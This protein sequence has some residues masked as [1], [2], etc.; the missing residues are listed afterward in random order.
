[1]VIVSKVNELFQTSGTYINLELKFKLR[2]GT[3]RLDYQENLLV[4][5]HRRQVRTSEEMDTE[6]HN[7]FEQTV[8]QIEDL[9]QYI[10]LLWQGTN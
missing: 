7:W 2:L 10:A 6:T 5:I 4:R 3:G 8:N 1:M 9:D